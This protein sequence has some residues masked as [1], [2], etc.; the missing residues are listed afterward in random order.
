MALRCKIVR[1]GEMVEPLNWKIRNCG[2][3]TSRSRRVKVGGLLCSWPITICLLHFCDTSQRSR[4]DHCPSRGWLD[5]W[6]R[7]IGGMST[8]ESR[9]ILMKICAYGTLSTTSYQWISHGR[10]WNLRRHDAT[11]LETVA[12]CSVQWQEDDIWGLLF[13]CHWVVSQAGRF[14]SLCSCRSWND[15]QLSELPMCY[16]S[17]GAA[18]YEWN[19]TCCSISEHQRQ[20]RTDSQSSS[21]AA[22]LPDMAA[23]LHIAVTDLCVMFC[24]SGFRPRVS[25]STV[26]TRRFCWISEGT[27][28]S[29]TVVSFHVPLIH[30]Y[31][32][33]PSDI[34][35]QLIDF[36]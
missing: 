30:N 29:V 36:Y 33:H 9:N 1:N 6:I 32:L 16:T 2:T 21:D 3:V 26:L 19:G 31:P 8:G 11:W 7:S 15:V 28:E 22:R 12:Y 13:C 5:N 24:C 18:P 35:L 4:Q 27:S 34:T 20:I 25:G 17:S 10:N 14:V 23:D